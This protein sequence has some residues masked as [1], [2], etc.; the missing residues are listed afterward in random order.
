M[1]SKLP[2]S[3]AL[4]KVCVGSSP[5]VV[6]SVDLFFIVIFVLAIVDYAA[7]ATSEG[8]PTELFDESR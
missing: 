8:E 2:S 6:V 1:H 4:D 3:N 7:T 5:A